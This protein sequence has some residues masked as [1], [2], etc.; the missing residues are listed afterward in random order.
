[1]RFRAVAESEVAAFLA[2]LA[3]TRY[4]SGMKHTSVTVW[5]IAL[6]AALLLGACGKGGRTAAARAEFDDDDTQA[7]A[8]EEAALTTASAADGFGAPVAAKLVAAAPQMAANGFADAG[9][10]PA[11]AASPASDGAYERKLIRTGNLRLQVQSLS[12][13]RAATE[14]WVQSFGGYIS[15]SSESSH[16]LSLTVRIPSARFD[17]A[18]AQAAGM[19]KLKNKTISSEDV[20]ERFYDLQGRLETKRILLERYQ[21][22]LRQATKMSDILDVE[23]RINTVTADLESM[24]GRM[25][26]LAAQIDF[27]VIYISATLPPQQTEHGFDLPDTKSDLSQFAG[28]VAGFFNALLFAVLY[29][30]IFG[31]PLVVLLALLWWLCFGKLG[32]VRK[33]FV[34]LSRTR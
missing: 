1:M 8:F 25:N 32:L 4:H 24:Q 18:M 22:Y 29:A 30:V 33:L 10:N 3:P 23:A 16:D 6:C 12:D 11:E 28:N 34:R 14:R 19:G 7:F 13:T 21:Q 20:T 26:R 15:D 31:V 27:S 2:K 5:C 17:D 9:Y